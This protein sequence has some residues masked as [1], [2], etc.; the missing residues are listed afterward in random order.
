MGSCNRIASP[1][2]ISHQ[3]LPRAALLSSEI[4]LFLSTYWSESAAGRRAQGLLLKPAGMKDGQG[5]L[6]NESH[7][8]PHELL[9]HFTQVLFC[10]LFNKILSNRND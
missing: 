6:H 10:L 8:N 3:A 5:Q 4:Q 9:T 2:V 1:E 7:F